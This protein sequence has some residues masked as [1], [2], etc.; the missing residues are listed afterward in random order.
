MASTQPIDPTPT[1]LRRNWTS[2]ADL[3]YDS[4]VEAIFDGRFPPGTPLSIDGLARDFQISNTPVREALSRAA[5]QRLVT[6]SAN[7]GFTVAP[8]LS[9]AEYKQ[10]FDLRY[11]LEMHAVGAGVIEPATTITVTEIV[12]RMA[13]AGRQS[14]FSNFKSFNQDDHALHL[15]LVGMARNQFLIHAWTD[16]HFHLHIHRLYTG[17]GVIDR[18]ETL[19]EHQ[20]IAA[21]LQA[22][23]KQQLRQAVG[24]H[25]KQAEARLGPLLVAGQQA[26]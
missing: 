18:N 15:A 19:A 20:V 26:R 3:A 7:R 21:A 9:E 17:L 5:A 11:V 23:D 13:R 14:N 25:I 6:A 2:L 8:R 22:G 12:D 10:L 4:I 24:A 16:L 1:A